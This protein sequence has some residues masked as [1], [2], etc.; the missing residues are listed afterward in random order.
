MHPARARRTIGDRMY[1]PTW[2]AATM[3]SLTVVLAALLLALCAGNLAQAATATAGSGD[4]S[5]RACDEQIACRAATLTT[6]TPA[7]QAV[8]AATL[9]A[10]DPIPAS[11]PTGAVVASSGPE[12]TLDRSIAPLASRSPPAA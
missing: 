1:A 2:S 12:A 4:C 9:P 7:S 3:R 5:G 10:V 8:P 11:E 6:A